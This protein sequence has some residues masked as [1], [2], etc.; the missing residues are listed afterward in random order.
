[1]KIKG[2]GFQRDCGYEVPKSLRKWRCGGIY[3]QL[4]RF[5]RHQCNHLLFTLSLNNCVHMVGDVNQVWPT[6]LHVY[7]ELRI[8][9]LCPAAATDSPRDTG[10]VT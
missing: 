4:R 7:W 9:R 8:S 6:A 1:M 3:F 10:Q 5:P 2:W